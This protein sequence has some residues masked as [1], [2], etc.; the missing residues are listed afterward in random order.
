MVDGKAEWYRHLL[1]CTTLPYACMSNTGADAIKAAMQKAGINGGSLI[2]HF[3][4]HEMALEEH[5]LMDAA[6]LD[7]GVS[8]AGT[9]PSAATQTLASYTATC[10]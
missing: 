2:A 3:N 9:P 10:C 6:I 1:L 4:R 5:I 8:P 7:I